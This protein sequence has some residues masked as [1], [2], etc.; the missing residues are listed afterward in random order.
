M[1]FNLLISCKVCLGSGSGYL[2]QATPRSDLAKY[3][4]SYSLR[5]LRWYGHCMLEA[6]A[7]GAGNLVCDNTVVAERAP[8]GDLAG[9]ASR[10]VGRAHLL[11][12]LIGD[13]Q[14]LGPRLQT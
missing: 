12:L 9:P 1:A 4:L 13:V 10:P 6:P 14:H 8:Q 5:F 2:L 3:L 7:H 11:L